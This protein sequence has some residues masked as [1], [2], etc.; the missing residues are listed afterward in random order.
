M[1]ERT[2]EEEVKAILNDEK[3]K[4]EYKKSLEHKYK[5]AL[6][7]NEEL[8][9]TE[10]LNI[11]NLKQESFCGA[12]T[13]YSQKGLVFFYNSYDDLLAIVIVFYD[14]SVYKIVLE[15]TETADNFN[16]W[17]DELSYAKFLPEPYA[18]PA[19]L[20]ALSIGFNFIYQPKYR[21]H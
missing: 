11:D 20:V 19:D 21:K 3:F 14:S 17:Y 4:E 13:K 6:K 12:N 8:L 9:I 1:L 16:G 18:D 5:W 7:R 10:K 15:H 2:F